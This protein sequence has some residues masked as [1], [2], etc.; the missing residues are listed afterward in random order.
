[1]VSFNKMVDH[2]QNSVLAAQVFGGTS[3]GQ[4]Q[5]VVRG[6]IN[7][8]KSSIERKV[9][10]RLFGIGLIA[11]TMMNGR[12]DLISLLFAGTY[13]IHAMADQLQSLEGYHDLIIFDEITDNH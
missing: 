8:I 3:A 13:S 7:I 2:F 10:A 1:F 9:V 11:F 6:R 5:G 12:L 4:Y